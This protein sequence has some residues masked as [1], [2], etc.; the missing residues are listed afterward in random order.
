M[1]Q[2]LT[3]QNHYVPIWYQKGF[4]VDPTTSLFRLDLDPPKTVLPDGRVYPARPVSGPRAPTSW[5]WAEDLY[6]TR[7]GSAL[8]DEVERFLFGEIDNYGAL[9]VRAFASNDVAAIHNLFQ[10]FFAYLDAQKLRTPKGLDWIKSNYPN[11]TQLGLMM[12][13]QGLRQ[14]HLTMWYEA[15]RE[16]VSAEQ[17]DVKFIVTDHPVTIYNAAYPPTSA[18]CRYPN[19]PPIELNGSQTVFALDANHCLILT[20][21]EYAKEPTKVDL[22]APR[23]HAR[24][25]GQSMAR[26]DAFVR[27]RKLTSAEVTS[28]NRLLKARAHRYIAANKKDWLYPETQS[29]ESWAAIGKA[30]LPPANELW[31]FGGEMFI[32]YKDGTTYHQDEFGRTSGAHEYLKK[33]RRPI[34][35]NDPCGCGS[36]RKFRQCCD[37]VPEEDRPTWDVYSLR[38]RNL[39]FSRRV[40]DILG[41]LGTEKTWKDVQRELSDEQVKEVHEALESLWPKDT[42]ITQL[43]PRPDGKILR[44]L[45]LGL[46]DPRTIAVSVTSWLPYFDEICIPN[47]FV[48]AGGIRPEYSP[49]QSPGKYKTQ[50]LKNV[51][52]LMVLEPFIHAGLVHL[53]P[54]PTDFNADFRRAVWGMAEERVPQNAELDEDDMQRVRALSK[55]EYMRATRGLPIDALRGLITRATPDLS[56]E[57]TEKLIAY[58]KKQQENDPLALLQPM[59]PGEE[60]AQLQTVKGFN[61]E[62]ALFIAQLTGSMVYTDIRLHWRHLHSHT[63]AILGAKEASP[64]IPLIEGVKGTAFPL[65]G[66]P[67]IDLQLRMSRVL[68]DIRSAIRTLAI[69]VRSS[70]GSAVEGKVAKQFAVKMQ[71]T[72]KSLR[73]RWKGLTSRKEASAQFQGRMELSIPKGGFERP[74]VRRLLLTFGRAKSVQTMPMAIFVKAEGAE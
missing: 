30:L 22:K 63:S 56:P 55:D 57:D 39:M 33:K 68:D 6:T 15:V 44:A 51:F 19:D 20:N 53:I 28:I 71:G 24:Y 42:D 11:L 21:L 31:H 3:R 4:I 69:S 2:P 29:V 18:A 65:G 73:K 70:A 26:T 17:S 25:Y 5:F 58:L 41:I 27:S 16:V 47:P 23:T 8:N 72:K 59:Q 61:L 54:D 45:Y 48:N 14:M 1:D 35:K 46:V 38:E 9:A 10:R 74:A 64:W 67:Q 62:V 32:G 52:V 50:T 7:F 12:E 43:L 37:G 34:S 13:M 66:N 40:Q 60:G 49:T 36:G